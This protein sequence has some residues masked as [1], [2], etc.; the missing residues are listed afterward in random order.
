MLILFGNRSRG[1]DD[2]PGLSWRPLRQRRYLPQLLDQKF[3]LPSRSMKIGKISLTRKFQEIS[4]A[5][6]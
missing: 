6:H 4:R 2:V 3:Y 5:N 1:S